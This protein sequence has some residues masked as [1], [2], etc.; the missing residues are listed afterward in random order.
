[1]FQNIL[2][3]LKIPQMLQ[4]SNMVIR[5]YVL[6]KYV[7]FQYYVEQDKEID[8]K[9]FQAKSMKNLILSIICYHGGVGSRN[10]NSML[11]LNDAW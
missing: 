10:L 6:E 8:K 3:E 7:Q 5:M 11:N 4:K 9:I 1:M 2:P